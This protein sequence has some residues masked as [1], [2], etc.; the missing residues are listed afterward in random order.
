MRDGGVRLAAR[1]RAELAARAAGDDHVDAVAV[2]ALRRY[3]G[4]ERRRRAPF[5]GQQPQ[6]TTL[7]DDGHDRMFQTRAVGSGG[8]RDARAEVV[9][10]TSGAERRHEVH[11]ERRHCVGDANVLAA[12]LRA[13]SPLCVRLHPRTADMGS[14]ALGV[15]VLK[16]AAKT[17][18]ET[19]GAAKTD[20][21]Q[22]SK[23]NL[24]A[25][26]CLGTLASV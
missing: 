1:A 9:K 4:R 22:V 26:A 23:A 15:G 25:S 16:W 20:L 5:A 6:I 10:P 12:S 11:H 7:V 13:A 3:Q 14:T 8:R 17:E 21:P 2:R 24:I 18:P 19:N